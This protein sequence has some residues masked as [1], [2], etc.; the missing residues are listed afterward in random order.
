MCRPALDVC[1][2]VAGNVSLITKGVSLMES[3]NRP[4]SCRQTACDVSIFLALF[5]LAA[6]AASGCTIVMAAKNGLV[7]VGNNE[8]RRHLQ[9]VVTFM[10]ATERWHGRIIFGYDDAPVQGGMNDQGLFIDGNALRPTGWTPEPGK[11][12]FKGHLMIY[13]LGTCSTVDEVQAFFEKYNHPGLGNGR[14][15]VADRTG[16][17]MVVEYGQGR[18]QFVKS[19][20]WYQIATNFVIS[21]V[22]DGNYPCE[23]YRAADKILSKARELGLDLIRSVLDATH[24]EDDGLT[25]YSNIYDLKNGIIHLYNLRNFE[26]VVV[27]NLAEELKKGTRRIA[28]PSLFRTAAAE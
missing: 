21:N 12:A 4:L 13:I 25:V 26:D 3:R 5:L 14:F 22:T 27:L 18:V 17:S 10:P 16:A 9:T 28:L 8:D 23:R 19:E 24:Q 7:L 2:P 1:G 15:P 20:T 6:R 11:P